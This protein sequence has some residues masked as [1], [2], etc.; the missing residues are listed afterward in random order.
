VPCTS[1]IENASFETRDFTG[2]TNNTPA[3]GDTKI[4]GSTDGNYAVEN[5]DGSYLFNTWNGSA[6]DFYVTQTIDALKAGT[7]E[8]TALVA[9]DKGNK[10]TV[11][12]NNDA[13]EVAMENEKGIGTDVSVIFAVKE[14]ESAVIKV[15]SA[16]WFKADN[17]RLMYFGANSSKTPTAVEEVAAETEATTI[18]N[19]SGVRQNSLQKGLNIVK[20]GNTVKKIFVK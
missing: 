8:L 11:S 1:M 19:I 9:S 10:I 20:T 14:G 15:S 17:F 18:Y 3:T 16:S 12:V 5:A 2:W 4:V 6:V 7:Y 13:A